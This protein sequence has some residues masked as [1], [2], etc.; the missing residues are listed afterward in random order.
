M[1]QWGLPSSSPTAGRSRDVQELQPLP[2]LGEGPAPAPASASAFASSP[3]L[4]AT[5]AQTA[6]GNDSD[7]DTIIVDE[8]EDETM[9]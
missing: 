2:Y 3:P 5:R 9:N 7:G 1:P 6:N 4:R 8:Q